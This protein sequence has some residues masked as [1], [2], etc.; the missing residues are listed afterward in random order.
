MSKFNCENHIN[1]VEDTDC[2]YCEFTSKDTVE[3]IK[4]DLAIV[5]DCKPHLDNRTYIQLVTHLQKRANL[6]GEDW[7]EIG[8]C[9]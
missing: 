7:K 3:S 6:I 5:N 8:F 4:N 1:T 2:C 9:E